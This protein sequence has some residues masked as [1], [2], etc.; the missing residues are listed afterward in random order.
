MS[1]PFARPVGNGRLARLARLSA[2]ATVATAL[3][4]IAGCGTAPTRP[5][6][7]GAATP[8]GRAAGAEQVAADRKGAGGDA[9]GAASARREKGKRRRKA[10]EEAS[11]AA[12][13]DVPAAAESAYAAALAFMRAGS[14]PAAESGFEQL[15]RDYPMLPGP[16]VNAA[17]AYVH[18]GRDDDAIAALKKALEIDPKHSQANDELGVLLR[19]RGDFAGAEKAYRRALEADPGYPLALYNLGVLLDVYLRR[20]DEALAFYEQYQMTLPEPDK[21]VAGWIVDLKRRV[22]KQAAAA[23]RQPAAG[24]AAGGRAEPAPSAGATASTGAPAGAGKE[25]LR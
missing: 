21:K 9:G 10:A 7:S 11:P 23:D 1:A 24:S 17:I 16:Y 19:K 15:M 5:A 6:E 14:W 25:G 4:W 12:Q 2:C 18:D 13:D 20:Q 22:A 8:A 3:A